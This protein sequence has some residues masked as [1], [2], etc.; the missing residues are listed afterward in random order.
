MDHDERDLSELY[1]FQQKIERVSL[2]DVADLS[3]SLF[4]WNQMTFVI[5]G[6]RT[7]EETLKKFGDVVVVR[8][9]TIL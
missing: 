4:D 6:S 1:A 5:V 8:P 7:L 9:E 3:R 2:K